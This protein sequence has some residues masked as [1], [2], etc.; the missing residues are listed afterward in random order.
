MAFIVVVAGHDPIYDT[1]KK[2]KEAAL[3]MAMDGR[4]YLVVKVI[5]KT[6]SNPTF[7]K[8]KEP[9]KP[10]YDTEI[11]MNAKCDFCGDTAVASKKSETKD[12]IFLC[13]RCLGEG[14]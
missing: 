4:T 3:A 7:E 13:L 5:G 1:P 10:D 14:K 9:K 11:E 12:T 6:K 2:A 8:V